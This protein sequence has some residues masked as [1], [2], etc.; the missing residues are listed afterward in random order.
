M[1][2]LETRETK[3]LSFLVS[4]DFKTSSYLKSEAN[5][6]NIFTILRHCQRIREIRGPESIVRYSVLPPRL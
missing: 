5:R 1:R 6:R 3:G 2:A 4:E